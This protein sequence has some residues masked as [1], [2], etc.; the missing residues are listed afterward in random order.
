MMDREQ[1]DKLPSMQVD[2]IDGICLPVYEVRKSA[3]CHQPN[4][5]T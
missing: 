1:I 4:I 5:K 2:F 3:S